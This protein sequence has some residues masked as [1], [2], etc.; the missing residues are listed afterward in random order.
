MRRKKFLMIRLCFAK[1][2]R[3]VHWTFG[4]IVMHVCRKCKVGQS[5]VADVTFN[6]VV[7]LPEVR[8][9]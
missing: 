2:I 9:L 7:A 8:A 5:H 1:N 3:Q 6:I 4:M